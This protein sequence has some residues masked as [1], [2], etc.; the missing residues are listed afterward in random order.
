MFIQNS[1]FMWLITK[2]SHRSF[3]SWLPRWSSIHVSR[4]AS[5]N[6]FWRIFKYDYHDNG[7]H[8]VHH[9]LTLDCMLKCQPFSFHG[10][11]YL[12]YNKWV[13]VTTA[14]CI[15]RLRMKELPPIWW[16]D[17]NILNKQLQT[18]IK[19]WLSSLGVGWGA[20]NPHRKKLPFYRSLQ[21]L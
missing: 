4:K 21:L 11:Y 15:L 8:S 19:A 14:W 3:K 20:N 10:T 2:H 5:L 7:G 18:A 1:A 6:G 9:N 16:V 13:P 12:I 17:V